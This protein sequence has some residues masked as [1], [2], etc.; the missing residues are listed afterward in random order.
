MS[1]KMPQMVIQDNTNRPTAA[2][3]SSIKSNLL[4]GA[5][6]LVSAQRPTSPLPGAGLSPARGPDLDWDGD[7]DDALDIPAGRPPHANADSAPGNSADGASEILSRPHLLLGS[8]EEFPEVD[9]S[10][11]LATPVRSQE[12]KAAIDAIGP[13]HPLAICHRGVHMSQAS[14]TRP[15]EPGTKALPLPLAWQQLA[16]PS[17]A[18]SRRRVQRALSLP[19]LHLRSIAK[20]DTKCNRDFDPLSLAPFKPMT[21]N[22]PPDENTPT[23]PGPDAVESPP[24][25]SHSFNYWASADPNIRRAHTHGFGPNA[26]DLTGPPPP[27]LFHGENAY[28]RSLIDERY[29]EEEARERTS[30]GNDVATQEARRAG[31]EQRDFAPVVERARNSRG[32]GYTNEDGDDDREEMNMVGA[33]ETMRMEEQRRLVFAENWEDA[34]LWRLRELW[35]NR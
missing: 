31:V 4:A 15:G 24:G 21:D 11:K 32:P 35:F 2:D 13:G 5:P 14:N 10:C 26:P 16:A 33:P 7:F 22:L 17:A 29:N 30:R 6:N 19:P 34:G 18:P 23:A 3:S 8:G 27:S 28:V 25:L 9:P 20:E 12:Q 1:P